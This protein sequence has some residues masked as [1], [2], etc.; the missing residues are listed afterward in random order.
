LMAFAVAV[1]EGEV[2]AM[3]VLAWVVGEVEVV[4]VLWVLC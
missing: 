1:G 3:R 2:A 4:V